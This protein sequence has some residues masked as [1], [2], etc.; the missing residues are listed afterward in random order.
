MSDAG[1]SY[2]RT[3]ITD[4]GGGATCY[5]VREGGPAGPLLGTVTESDG[6]WNA[7]TVIAG[8][9]HFSGTPTATPPPGGWRTWP[10]TAR[11]SAELTICSGSGLGIPEFR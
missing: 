10:A 6:G 4:G 11:A 9:L 3:V 5:E 2:V 1:F 7:S 8:T